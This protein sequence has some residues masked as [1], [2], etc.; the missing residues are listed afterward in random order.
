MFFGLWTALAFITVT[1][2]IGLVLHPS[3]QSC[4]VLFVVLFISSFMFAFTFMSCSKMVVALTI[5]VC[6]LVSGA[7]CIFVPT[8]LGAVGLIALDSPAKFG[9]LTT[10]LGDNKPVP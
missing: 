7:A 2:G 8:P 3:K 1:S 10:P 9:A 4:L 6:F 5:L